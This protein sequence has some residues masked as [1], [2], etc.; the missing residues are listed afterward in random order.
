VES[1]GF[2]IN[3]KKSQL[4]PTQQ[5]EL[6]WVV[7]RFQGPYPPTARE[8]VVKDSKKLPEGLPQISIQELTKFLGLLTTA[9]QTYFSPTS[10]SPHTSNICRTQKN[11]QWF[12]NSCTKP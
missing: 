11:K 1:L 8:I 10:P 4:V 2:I 12:H 6:F 5:L 9:I 7:R 3:Y